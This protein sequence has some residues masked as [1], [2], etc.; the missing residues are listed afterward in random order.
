MPGTS[1]SG[2]ETLAPQ[3]NLQFSCDADG[4]TPFAVQNSNG[5]LVDITYF[6]VPGAVTGSPVGLTDLNLD[7]G[8]VGTNM[9]PNNV[10]LQIVPVDQLP[11][12]PQ[13]GQG[14]ITNST[15]VTS[16]KIWVIDP[17]QPHKSSPPTVPVG[18]THGTFPLL[19][20]ND[21]PIVRI[22]NTTDNSFNISLNPFKMSTRPAYDPFAHT[23]DP[24][25]RHVI[26][27]KGDL[28][29]WVLGSPNKQ[30][31]SIDIRRPA[32]DTPPTSLAAVDP[33][34]PLRKGPS[35][36]VAWVSAGATLGILVVLVAAVIIIAMK[37]KS[38]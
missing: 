26:Y 28:E 5:Q 24:D 25:D 6:F 2:T 22:L 16:W 8:V 29:F 10:G 21:F 12:G 11:P 30:G 1:M 9:G 33:C 36:A 37:R 34:V 17:H 23:G 32:R 27:S 31:Y 18:Q 38:M 14:T 15:G 7:W 4:R 3:K 20:V 19:P 35:N 13:L